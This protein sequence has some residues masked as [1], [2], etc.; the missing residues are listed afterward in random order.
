MTDFLGQ[1]LNVGDEVVYMRIDSRSLSKAE[2][3]SV[4]KKMV[5]LW[6]RKPDIKTRQFHN[7]VVKI[8]EEGK[9]WIK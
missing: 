5:T 1:E 7:Q 9:P 2:V 3:A 6:I 4:G 8:N